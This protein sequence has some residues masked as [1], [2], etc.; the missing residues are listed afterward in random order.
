MEFRP[1]EHGTG[2]GTLTPDGCAVE[3]YARLPARGEP[4]LIHDAIPE[5]A[6]ILEL[7]SG[8]GRI[9]Q[10]LLALGH[11]VVAVDESAAMLAHVRGAETICSPIE[12]LSLGRQFDVVLLASHLIETPQDDLRRALLTTCRTHVA[13]DGQV[14]IERKPSEWYDSAASAQSTLGEVKMCMRDVRRPE[15]DLLAATIEYTLGDRVWTQSFVSRRIDD[16][17]LTEELAA[18]KLRLAGFLTPDRAWIR[19]LPVPPLL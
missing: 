8:A 18:A 6:T 3:L 7:G 15:R 10:P 17:F 2:P 9:T 5:A 12:T 19:A 1:H 4:E 16:D 13:M 11:E 14:I